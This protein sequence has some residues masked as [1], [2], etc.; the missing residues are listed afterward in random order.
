MVSL[1]PL[2]NTLAVP[3]E[4]AR[5]SPQVE[6]AWPVSFHPEHAAELSYGVT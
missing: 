6:A 3:V 1:L 4:R 5:S 2:V